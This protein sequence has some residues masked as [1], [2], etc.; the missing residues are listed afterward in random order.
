M[1]RF[2]DVYHEMGNRL[3]EVSMLT[4]MAADF[5]RKDAIRFRKKINAISR[6]A[7]VLLCSHL[8]AYIRELGEK[9]LDSLSENSTPRTNLS[10]RVYYH[11]SI[12]LLENFCAMNNPEKAANKIFEFIE[13]DISFWSKSGPFPRPVEAK[14][15]NRG[16]STPKFNKIK[17]YFNRFGYTSYKHDLERC[18]KADFNPTVTMVDHLVDT[19]NQIAHGDFSISLTPLDIN[20]MIQKILVFCQKTEEVFAIWWRFSVCGET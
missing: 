2:T 4:E 12:D 10:S 6:G 3:E 7:I 9:A 13:K 20:I 8:E 17:G 18:L 11:I 14:R 15:F 16:F 1:Q 19:R 5:E